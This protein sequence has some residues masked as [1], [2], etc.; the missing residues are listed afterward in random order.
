ML[1][2]KKST[3]QSLTGSRA[4][5]SQALGPNSRTD[6]SEYSVVRFSSPLLKYVSYT[7]G[8]TNENASQ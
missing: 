3:P 2:A 8:E 7:L 4:T 6:A 5:D 1:K